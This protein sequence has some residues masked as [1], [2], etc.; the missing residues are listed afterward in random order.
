MWPHVNSFR[1]RS[2]LCSTCASPVRRRMATARSRD[3]LVKVSRA[4]RA[5]P[6]IT[7]PARGRTMSDE[8]HGPHRQA[9]T[10]RVPRVRGAEEEVLTHGGSLHPG[11][12]AYI[13]LTGFHGHQSGKSLVARSTSTSG[14]DGALKEYC[15]TAS[16]PGHPGLSGSN[17]G[18]FL[19]SWLTCR[20]GSKD[21]R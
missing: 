3:C 16:R 4:S 17:G 9:N 13:R 15:Q 11:T 8:A 2:R 5:L 6:A 7:I 18:A 1:C 12:A 20:E 10:L 14:C 19:A 21:H